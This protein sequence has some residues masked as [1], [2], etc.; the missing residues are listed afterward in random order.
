MASEPPR[1]ENCRFWRRLTSSA[2]VGR[3]KTEEAYGFSNGEWVY[4][5]HEPSRS[6]RGN[7]G[8]AAR[9]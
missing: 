5:H 8:P 7:E 6:S 3:C 9:Q 1:C 2:T 4:G